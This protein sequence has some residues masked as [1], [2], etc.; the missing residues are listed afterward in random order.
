MPRR[1][2]PYPSLFLLL[3]VA[4]LPACK[5]DAAKRTLFDCE[6]SYLTDMDDPSVQ[7]VRVCAGAAVE[8]TAIGCAQ[9]AAPAPIEG[10]HCKPAVG[11]CS[12]DNEC[13][14]LER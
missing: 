11:A 9:A 4:A 12:A 7:R 3:I 6:C 13:R 14:A 5:G 2:V 1:A 8:Q 10:C